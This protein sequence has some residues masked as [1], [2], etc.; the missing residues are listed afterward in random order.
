MPNSLRA[1]LLITH[2]APVVVGLP[3]VLYLLA[4]GDSPGIFV[5]LPLGAAVVALAI[6]LAIVAARRA[7]ERLRLL[8]TAV[9]Q[10][11]GS[12]LDVRAAATLPASLAADAPDLAE[13]FDRL[14]VGVEQ[15][16]EEA[17]AGRA[18]LEAVLERSAAGVI[19]VDGEGGLRYISAAAQRLLELDAT[20]AHADDD[21]ARS[22]VSVVRSH[23][24]AAVLRRS[25]ETDAQVIEVLQVGA[26]HRPVET[27]FLPLH[28]AGAWRYLGLLRDLTESR[29]TEGQRRDF[30]TNVSHELR[31]P[32]ASIKAVVQVLAEGGLDDAEQTREFL[33]AV[34]REVDRLSQLVEEMLDL[35]RIESGQAPFR[36]EAVEAAELCAEAARRLT[37]QAERQNLTLSWSAEPALP[38]LRA[39]RERLLRALINL[40][41]NAIKFTP[42]GGAVEVYARRRED[43]VALGVRDTGCGIARENLERIFE[44]FYKADRARATQGTGL[45]LAIVKHTAQAHHGTVEVDSVPGEGSDFRIVIP[46]DPR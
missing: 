13:A 45:G 32:L 7:D 25:Q 9:Q 19:A 18:R 30:V 31:T 44:R 20:A 41:H 3:L 15:A 38:P 39:D 37:L 22:F 36:F 12:Q 4:S 26:A 34:D 33:L 21:G 24:V 40:V 42:A 16:M 6:V 14:A 23:E 35:S 2:L 11:A 8:T 5:V 10:L 28:G 29:G 27:I 17:R 43:A 46:L 1:R